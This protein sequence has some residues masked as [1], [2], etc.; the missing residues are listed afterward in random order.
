[1]AEFVAAAGQ[2]GLAASA[3]SESGEEGGGETAAL[4]H[5]EAEA[6]VV[7]HVL[8]LVEVLGGEEQKGLFAVLSVARDGQGGRRK[9]CRK[10][11][12]R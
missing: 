5:E 11:C 1:M 3:S 4:K 2:V 7:H 9:V 8:T 10:T 12:A 6:V